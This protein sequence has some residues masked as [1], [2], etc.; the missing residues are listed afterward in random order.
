MEMNSAGRA[1]IRC[2]CGKRI[3]LI[4]SFRILANRVLSSVRHRIELALM[5]F[6][7]RT[8]FPKYLHSL[9]DVAV[10]RSLVRATAYSEFAVEYLTDLVWAR[11]HESR[12]RNLIHGLN[13]IKWVLRNRNARTSQI[14]ASTV[15]RLFE[16]YQHFIFDRLDEIR[17]SVSAILKDKTLRTGQRLEQRLFAAWLDAGAHQ[18]AHGVPILRAQEVPN[19]SDHYA[20]G[21][22]V[23]R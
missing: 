12:R 14:P 21:A 23:Q 17:W 19:D 3:R 6:E 16:L 22:P 11:V 8:F 4:G 18:I 5:P 2:Q 1:E 10:H 13:A 20:G 7:P 15:D 9:D